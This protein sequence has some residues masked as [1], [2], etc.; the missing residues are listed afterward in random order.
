MRRLCASMLRLVAVLLILAMPAM[1]ATP[2]CTT[3]QGF[4]EHR[5]ENVR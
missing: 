4:Q 2:R 3:Y 1:A 5:P